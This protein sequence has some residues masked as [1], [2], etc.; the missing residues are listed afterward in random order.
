[1]WRVARTQINLIPDRRLSHCFVQIITS[2]CRSTHSYIRIQLSAHST[3]TYLN[4]QPPSTLLDTAPHPT[5]SRRSPPLHGAALW[6]L[7]RR[8]PNPPSTVP[9]HNLSL[10]HPLSHPPTPSCGRPAVAA[11]RE[12]PQRRHDRAR[13]HGALLVARAAAEDMGRPIR[14]YVHDAGGPVLRGAR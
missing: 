3:F 9:T 6:M 2:L 8:A 12:R 14:S 7:H 11:R 1:M 5:A 4:L 10:T 13:T